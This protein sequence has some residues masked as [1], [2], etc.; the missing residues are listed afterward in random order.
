M[1]RLEELVER[2]EKATG[3]DR[4]VDADI[5]E[6]V[7]TFN[8]RRAGPGWPDEDEYVVPAFPGW[9]PLPAYTASI[10]AALTLVP[11]EAYWRLG[12][13][14]DGA[15]PSDYRADV[16]LPKLGGKDA[17]GRSVASTAALALASAALRARLS[18]GE[19][20]GS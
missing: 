17:R 13:D 15:D 16:I 8:C 3:P 5:H 14:G 7:T 20:E 10:D 2:I 19:G 4:W 1:D 6:A 18:V 11:E 9:K 12:H